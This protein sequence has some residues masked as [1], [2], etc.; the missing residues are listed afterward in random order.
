MGRLRVWPPS[1]PFF[2]SSMASSFGRSTPYS[3]CCPSLSQNPTVFSHRAPFC[4]CPIFS[5]CRVCCSFPYVTFLFQTSLNDDSALFRAP[6]QDDFFLAGSI[7]SPLVSFP[8]KVPRF[9]L[10]VLVL[11]LFFPLSRSR[12]VF[13]SGTVFPPSSSGGS[14]PRWN[15]VPWRPP[16][17]FFPQ[18]VPSPLFRPVGA[19]V[20][21]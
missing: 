7:S 19:T 13:F 5:T 8:N 18:G 10:F 11:W 14:R 20:L 16:R 17:P 12:A 4:L 21:C 9:S 2:F 15:S 1:F 6:C 3:T